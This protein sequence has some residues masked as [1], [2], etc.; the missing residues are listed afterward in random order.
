MIVPTSGNGSRGRRMMG[1]EGF[2]SKGGCTGRGAAG[3]SEA[4]GQGDEEGE[5]EEET[6]LSES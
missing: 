1:G 3:G 5:E 6:S 2:C 4:A